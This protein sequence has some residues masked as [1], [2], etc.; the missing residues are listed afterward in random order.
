[1]PHRTCMPAL[2]LRHPAVNA[3]VVPM[4]LSC[5]C[6]TLSLSRPCCVNATS[7]PVE[8]QSCHAMQLRFSG[9]FSVFL[10]VSAAFQAFLSLSL[11]T[12]GSVFLGHGLFSFFARPGS[13][14]GP[15]ASE[16]GAE[17][18]ADAPQRSPPCAYR[19]GAALVVAYLHFYSH[20]CAAHACATCTF[21]VHTCGTHG[22]CGEHFGVSASNSVPPSEASGPG[23]DPG[24]AKKE[25]RLWPRN[26]KPAVCMHV[27]T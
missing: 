27:S 9:S 22:G 20:E 13:K 1:M 11:L 5:Q 14:L 18:A 4:S 3:T 26:T 16:G 10:A 8:P 2:R 24:R 7:G 17:S 23:F 19:C 12:A 25:K 21:H 15:E 6:H